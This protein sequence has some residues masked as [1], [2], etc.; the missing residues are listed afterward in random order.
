MPAS[1]VTAARECSP[2]DSI[3]IDGFVAAVIDNRPELPPENKRV[4]APRPDHH[5]WGECRKGKQ[6]EFVAAAKTGET[7]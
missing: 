4:L 2:I 7:G 3:L 5:D 1:C 6:A